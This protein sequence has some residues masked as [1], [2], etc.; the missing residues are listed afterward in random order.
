MQDDAQPLTWETTQSPAA[1]DAERVTEGVFSHGRSL[2]K[3]GQ[4]QPLACF[5]RRD[6]VVVAGA[7]GRTE[8]RR[9]FVASLWVSEPLRHRGLGS[10]T[11]LRLEAEAA[12]RG[13]SSALLETLSDPAAGLYARLGY[14]T[15]A[16]IEEYV[17]PFHRHIML[18][19]LSGAET[20][21]AHALAPDRA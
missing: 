10:E 3:D 13:C 6:G 8:Y 21:D 9:L 7:V 11:L 1:A 19:R 14:Q 5:A 20:A 16:V 2:A 18:K 15:L 17:G 4:A 12:R